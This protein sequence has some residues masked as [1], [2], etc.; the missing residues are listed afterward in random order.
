MGKNI[1]KAVKEIGVDVGND[2]LKL[3]MNGTTFD[4]KEKT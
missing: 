2:A 1:V 4:G 3:C